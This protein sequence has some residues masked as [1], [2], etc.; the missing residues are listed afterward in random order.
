MATLCEIVISSFVV[1]GSSVPKSS[2]DRFERRHDLDHDE[3]Q[4]TD[5]H[6]DDHDWVNHGT[7]D[8]AFECFG[9][10]LEVGQALQNGFQRTARFAGFDHVDV[11]PIEGFGRLGH[12]FGKRRAAF[13]LF[14]HIEQRI[15]K[16]TRFALFAQDS[17][18]AKNGRP[19]F[20]AEW[21]AVA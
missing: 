12:G 3:R 18:A 4:D 8:F 10:F 21:T 11:Q 19:A 1:V 5:G 9:A 6:H 14:A 17:Q 16:S 2:E 13:N 7:L 15:L 20:L